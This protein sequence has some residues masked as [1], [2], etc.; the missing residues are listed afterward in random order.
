MSRWEWGCVVL[1]I[2][3][4]AIGRALVNVRPGLERLVMHHVEARPRMCEHGEAVSARANF[5]VASPA[6]RAG[7]RLPVQ[8]T[9]DGPGISLPLM[10]KGAPD[11]TSSLVL[12][13]ED[14]DSPTLEP[15]V[16]G[17]AWV[18]GRASGEIREG[19]LNPSSEFP[20]PTLGRNSYLR[21]RYMPPDPP[22]GHGPHR[23]V[24]QMFSLDC[25]LHFV[26][27]PGRRALLRA[28]AGHVLAIGHLTAT[29]ERR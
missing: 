29:Y 21:A 18:I 9:A 28:F 4:S 19:A 13:I 7:D 20:L 14:A 12:I 25:S 3:P 17:I 26:Q 27:T 10:W 5:H 23:Y 2:V 15:M 24:F 8:Y 11:N 1:Q 22:R 6:F 16:H